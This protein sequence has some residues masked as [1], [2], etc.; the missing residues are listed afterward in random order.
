MSTPTFSQ[1]DINYDIVGKQEQVQFHKQTPTV[2]AA[3]RHAPGET[4]RGGRRGI[5]MTA[6]VTSTVREARW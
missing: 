6:S 1:N 5:W 2:A 3:R 4:Q